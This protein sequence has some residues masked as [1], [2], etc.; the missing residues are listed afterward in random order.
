M[1]GGIK[2]TIFCAFLALPVAASAQDVPDLRGTWSLENRAIQLD[3]QD[4]GK[5]PWVGRVT[6]TFEIAW[7]EGNLFYGHEVSQDPDPD[8]T[9]ISSE[10]RIA[11]AIN[12]DNGMAFLV[13]DN[14]FRDCWII[15]PDE[16]NC[17]YRHADA[18]NSVVSWNVWTRQ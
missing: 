9:I 14:G 10:E 13:D 18:K 8:G 6:A 4:S 15:S 1:T 3:K 11:G 7:Q 12:A 17:V 5:Q 2:L 16:M